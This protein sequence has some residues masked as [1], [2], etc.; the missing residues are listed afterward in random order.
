M[1]YL[2]AN[3]DFDTA[4][5]EPSKVWYRGLT[6]Y[7]GLALS[8]YLLQRYVAALRIIGGQDELGGQ[9]TVNL[10][11]NVG[12]VVA[13]IL[14]LRGDLKGRAEVL[15]EVAVELGES[16]GVAGDATGDESTSNSKEEKRKKKKK[17]GFDPDA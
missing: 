6:S 10:V 2:V 15:E 17:K 12:V 4:E 1:Y 14:L 5:N 13:A 8:P 7:L 3:I 9:G 11:V 16:E